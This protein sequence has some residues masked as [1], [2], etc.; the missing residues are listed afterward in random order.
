[1][2]GTQR[3]NLSVRDLP[4]LDPVASSTRQNGKKNRHY[5][6]FTAEIKHLQFDF[7]AKGIH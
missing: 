1:M 4:V 7:K 2:N 5:S 6:A 3:H